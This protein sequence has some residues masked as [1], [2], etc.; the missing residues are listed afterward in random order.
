MEDRNQEIEKKQ[1]RIKNRKK[2][3][4][5]RSVLKWKTKISLASMK[6][7]GTT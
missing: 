2:I 3:H 6:N 4:R 7:G 1:N 5:Q